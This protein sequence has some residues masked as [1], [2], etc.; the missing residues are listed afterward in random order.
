MIHVTARKVIKQDNKKV[1]K[2]VFKVHVHEM[3]HVTARKVIKQDNKKVKQNK[4]RQ[5]SG[6][7]SRQVLLHAREKENG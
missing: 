2:V 5:E 6:H 4:T 7:S 3:I 1:K